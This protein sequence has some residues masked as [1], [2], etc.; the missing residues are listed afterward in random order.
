MGT[1]RGQRDAVGVDGDSEDWDGTMEIMRGG[2]GLG[3]GDEDRKGT[4]W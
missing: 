4:L 1:G 3:G 2:E